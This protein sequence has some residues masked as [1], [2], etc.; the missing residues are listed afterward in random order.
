MSG[1]GGRR[2]R[3]R[4]A[5]PHVGQGDR[6]RMAASHEARKGTVTIEG[7]HATIAFT[8]RYAHP[9]DAV[10][11]TLTEPEH[12][13]GWYMTKAKLDARP[14][15]SI[16]YV[17]GISQFHVQGKILAWDPPRV[18]EHEWNVEP[19]PYLPQGERGVVRWELTPDG[20]GT[21]LRI[22]HTHLTQQ[23]AK[24]FVSGT[25][26][27]LDRLGEELDGKPLSNWVKRVDELRP[28]YGVPW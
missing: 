28:L 4:E 12:L 3:S 18:F 14:G 26:A 20:D 17:S 7:D 9:I 22:T 24:G 10:W 5:S 25:H 6:A 15:G 8:R 11:K 21:I 2:E 1:F 19:Q 16:D 13:A 23:T 27:F